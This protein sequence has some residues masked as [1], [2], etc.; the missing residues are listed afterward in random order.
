MQKALIFIAGAAAGFV[1]GTRSGR[2]T[3]EKMR[4]QSLELWHN[5]TV[6]EKVS[7]VA[8]TV[9]EKAPQVQHKVGDLAK[10]ASHHNAETSTASGPAIG[11]TPDEV[12]TP[13]PTA[14]GNSPGTPAPPD[15]AAPSDSGQGHTS[16]NQN[17]DP[18]A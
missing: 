9:K 10:K 3:Y 12:A 18:K 5:P 17:P 15:D 11:E 8:E 4:D 1:V 14:E 7:E 2:Q 16:H 6:Q 13:T